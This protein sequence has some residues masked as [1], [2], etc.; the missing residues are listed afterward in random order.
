MKPK[1]ITDLKY[2]SRNKKLIDISI[3]VGVATFCLCS[4]IFII[5]YCNPKTFPCLLKVKERLQSCWYRTEERCGQVYFVFNDFLWLCWS[6]EHHTYFHVFLI[7]RN[8]RI[9]SI[10]SLAE[11][12]KVIYRCCKKRVERR[13][14]EKQ[15]EMVPQYEVPE[16][17][18]VEVKDDFWYINPY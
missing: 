6:H 11:L 16:E 3:G 5:V 17:M 15:L 2:F 8:H 4:L 7:P 9:L 13:R 12:N 10:W 18:K 1:K 14:R